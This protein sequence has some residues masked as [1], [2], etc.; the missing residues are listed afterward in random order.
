MLKA[1]IHTKAFTGYSVQV[2]QK[3]SL[4]VLAGGILED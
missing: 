1:K 3:G 2:N 4:N